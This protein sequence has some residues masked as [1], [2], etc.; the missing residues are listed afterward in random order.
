L[1]KNSLKSADEALEEMKTAK[2]KY[3]SLKN[4]R[5]VRQIMHTHKGVSSSKLMPERSA[6]PLADK[7]Y[8]DPSFNSGTSLS[9]SKG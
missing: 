5:R 9:T 1:K 8:K 2:M 7:A 3:D 4:E 6:V